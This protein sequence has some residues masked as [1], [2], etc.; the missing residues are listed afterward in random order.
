MA[1]RKGKGVVS[2]TTAAL[3]RLFAPLAGGGRGL[4]GVA[5]MAILLIAG[6]YI[7]WA[8]WGGTIQQS[9]QYVLTADSFQITPQPPWI[10][11]D[12][13]ADVMPTEASPNCRF[14]IRT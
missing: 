3:R 1:S 14:S 5:I 6:S 12:V 9:P 7:G 4:F 8:K 10:Q 13:K 2:T 11:S